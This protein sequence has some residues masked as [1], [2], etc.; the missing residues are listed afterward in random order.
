MPSN[1]L[2][3]WRTTGLGR[4]TELEKVH[5]SVTPSGPGRKWGT[6]QLNRSLT[7]ALVAQFQKFAGNCTTKRSPS[8]LPR[9]LPTKVF[10]CGRS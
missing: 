9:R 2:T 8:M 10:F 4:L 1:S 7:V 6:N 3:D 5:A